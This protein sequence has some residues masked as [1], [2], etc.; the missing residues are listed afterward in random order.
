MQALLEEVVLACILPTPEGGADCQLRGEPDLVGYLEVCNLTT[1]DHGVKVPWSASFYADPIVEICA[2]LH[3]RP[4][5]CERRVF[6]AW[7]GAVQW[8]LFSA[9]NVCSDCVR[10]PVVNADDD[11][12]VRRGVLEVQTEVV[13]RFACEVDI[14]PQAQVPEC[15]ERLQ[16]HPLPHA[17]RASQ[18]AQ[19]AA[20][21][22]VVVIDL[23][24]HR[25]SPHC[26]VVPIHHFNEEVAVASAWATHG[27]P[28]LVHVATCIPHARAR[29]NRAAQRLDA[30]GV[31]VWLCESAQRHAA[32][33]LRMLSLW[34]CQSHRVRSQVAVGSSHPTVG[35]APTVVQCVQ[36]DE[37]LVLADGNNATSC[38]QAR[39]T[40]PGR[41]L[42]TL[43]K[44]H[45]TA[46]SPTELSAVG[47]TL[48]LESAPFAVVDTCR[49]R[50]RPPVLVV[51]LRNRDQVLC[52]PKTHCVLVDKFVIHFLLAWH[53]GACRA[54]QERAILVNEERI[55]P[56]VTIDLHALPDDFEIVADPAN[57]CVGWVGKSH[58]AVGIHVHEDELREH[59][60]RHVSICGVPRRLLA[61]G[62]RDATGRA[63][64]AHESHVADLGMEVQRDR[65]VAHG[66]PLG[67]QVMPIRR[68]W[69]ALHE[70]MDL[71]VGHADAFATR[72]GIDGAALNHKTHLPL[73]VGHALRALG[74]ELD[75]I[76]A[77][78]KLHAPHRPLRLPGLPP[79]DARLATV[80]DV[81]G[82]AQTP[83]D[84]V[85]H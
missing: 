2:V 44:E 8:G 46:F 9:I 47:T 59:D 76:I 60:R 36:L 38:R 39:H 1:P 4:Q 14:V 64:V 43:R 27:I 72:A 69:V 7:C 83:R 19:S 29:V 53:D 75:P 82:D 35:I 28:S 15:M 30:R 63:L 6:P 54:S 3:I 24:S 26:H 58:A 78:H 65:G 62:E 70:A 21:R 13:G 51:A 84:K 25:G 42:S 12:L 10:H 73:V 17:C 23:H 66:I 22:R 68:Q 74:V 18:H 56:A 49:K 45:I 34:P 33:A 81:V 20:L 50:N 52:R 5:P 55:L 31:G 41:P 61:H 40:C 57:A 79:G 16:R 37:F 71:G 32:V 67:A 48:E 77:I 11:A 80:H 85:P